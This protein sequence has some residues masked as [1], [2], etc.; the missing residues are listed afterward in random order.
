MHRDVPQKI[1]YC[2]IVYQL[3]KK[4]IANIFTLMYKII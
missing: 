4:F 3:T 2:T 1:I